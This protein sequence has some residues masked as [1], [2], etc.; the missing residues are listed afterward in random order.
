MTHAEKRRERPVA[1]RVAGGYLPPGM[2]LPPLDRQGNDYSFVER[3]VRES[4][5]QGLQQTRPVSV[6]VGCGSHPELLDQTLST[7]CHQTYPAD[8]I[9][10]LVA[11]EGLVDGVD[12]VLDRHSQTLSLV[13]V[14]HRKTSSCHVRNSGIRA[15][16]S[17]HIILLE[18]GVLAAP[19]LVENYMAYLQASD[20]CLLFGATASLEAGIV[21]KEDLTEGKLTSLELRNR[22]TPALSTESEH[23]VR[24]DPTRMPDLK[25]SG[26]Q[27]AFS[28]GNCAFPRDLIDQA[29][30]FDEEFD[31]ATCED[32]EFGFRA[33]NAGYY[34]V[35]L[36]EALAL[37]LSDVEASSPAASTGA[38][39]RLEQRCP[40]SPW[41][42]YRPGVSYEVPKVSIYMP[43]FNTAPYIRE[44]VESV[45]S[46]SY[47]DLEVCIVDDGSTDGTIGVL[48]QHYSDDPR[49]RWK[50]VP[51]G[52]IGSASNAAVRMCRGQYIG[53]LDSD[54]LLKPEAVE[55]LLDCL[56]QSDAGCAYSTYEFMDPEGNFIRKGYHWP[57]FSR[58]KLMTGMIVHPFRMFRKRDWMRT[59]GFAEDLVNSVD[60][61]IIL[62]LAEVCSFIH[63]P[64][65]LYSYRRH[66][67]NTTKIHAK[68][69]RMTSRTA[70]ARA[71]S[72]M[73][74]YHEWEVFSASS[75]IDAKKGYRRRVGSPPRSERALPKLPGPQSTDPATGGADEQ[76]VATKHRLV[77]GPFSCAHALVDSRN[78]LRNRFRWAIY[79]RATSLHVDPTFELVT[80]FFQGA[81]E[82][83]S[84][85][86]AIRAALGFPVV[87]CVSQQAGHSRPTVELPHISGAG[88]DYS[89][90]EARVDALS[91]REFLP[92]RAAT[93]VVLTHQADEHLGA[94]E[95]AIAGQSY[96]A[97][98]VEV[99]RAAT[100]TEL[101][102]AIR[103]T[104]SDYII[105]LDAGA[106]PSPNLVSE[107]MR[108]FHV[109]EQIVLLGPTTHPARDDGDFED[110]GLDRRT[111]I[112]TPGAIKRLSAAH[113]VF[114]AS[115]VC[116]SRR[117]A[118]S[119]GL[120]SGEEGLG[121]AAWRGFARRLQE[122]GLY[123]V[124]VPSATARVQTEPSSEASRIAGD[125][126]V[127]RVGPA[128]APPNVSIIIPTYNAGSFIAG[129]IDSVL[130]QAGLDLQVIVC[131]LGSTD[132]TAA[133][134][135]RQYSDSEN[136]CWATHHGQSP[137]AALNAAISTCRGTFVGLLR[138]QDELLPGAIR[139]S[140][141]HL[142]HHPER[143][144][145]YTGYE[146]M[147]GRGKA[148][149]TGF[150]WPGFSRKKLL[151]CDIVTPFQL[152]RKRDYWR[153]GGFGESRIHSVE[154]DF[155]FRLSEV[156]RFFQ[157]DQVLYR[158]RVAETDRLVSN[159]REQLKSLVEFSREC[160]ERYGLHKNWDL[161]VTSE[162]TV[163]SLELKRRS[164]PWSQKPQISSTGQ[165]Q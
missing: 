55:M 45:L 46:Q 118:L 112:E 135:R 43:A 13:Q 94:T 128:G 72:R 28:S 68:V 32:V 77:I 10:V 87:V 145:V 108:W 6:V 74:L 59:E 11:Y 1:D 119:V 113:E 83:H 7:L 111:L 165:S 75:A 129:A 35:P 138:G 136:I 65:V 44:A 110:S 126:T 15:A 121:A 139:L 40:A 144:C 149:A 79:E 49:V 130:G 58:D 99:R 140:L 48:E 152:F 16:K 142:E 154:H 159:R 158:R 164:R 151:C 114:S 37:R 62:K 109:T 78:A 161:A 141:E 80:G 106:L 4:R 64:K 107:Y 85:A 38:T 76:A 51:H 148:I 8:L 18:S 96:P 104:S 86:E 147:D 115:N 73:G 103:D 163:R 95:A 12:S 82:A 3:L 60:Y 20:R 89:F 137:G 71:L 84:A 66:T 21:S 162:T 19:G 153:A 36:Q 30:F 2:V 100:T 9:E 105:L 125:W 42:R 27:Q 101:H 98:L 116:F 160:L 120:P 24:P 124:A 90:L 50:S 29:G 61:D 155:F 67:T 132:G 134:L 22:F 122:I 23:D 26:S 123:F 150:S 102:A 14:R 92:T 127:G 39:Q 53:Q 88:N 57:V 157:L 31:D 97:S 33:C 146:E 93:I 41:R 81:E 52:G 17:R 63:I 70:A 34:L 54:D 133:L 69:Q 91:E 131:D 56:E 143:G 5:E 156:C 25:K 47:T 117:Q